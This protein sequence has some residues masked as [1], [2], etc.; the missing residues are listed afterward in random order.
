MDVS[1]SDELSLDGSESNLLVEAA[2][3]NA[4]QT[5]TK[6]IAA[7]EDE[8]AEEI[9]DASEDNSAPLQAMVA[10]ADLRTVDLDVDD[11]ETDIGIGNRATLQLEPEMNTETPVSSEFLETETA[12]TASEIEAGEA[13]GSQR[14]GAQTETHE[15]VAETPHDIPGSAA[16]K[17]EFSYVAFDD[18]LPADESIAEAGLQSIDIGVESLSLDDSLHLGPQFQEE[19]AES[20]SSSGGLVVAEVPAPETVEVADASA[21]EDAAR[22]SRA[23]RLRFVAGGGASDALVDLTNAEFV[24]GR[25]SDVAGIAD[26]QFVSP[27]HCAVR[28]E[29]GIVELSDLGSLNGTWL[30]ING[31]AVLS[32]GQEIRLGGQRFTIQSAHTQDAQVSEPADGT[33][34]MDDSQP[35]TGW[36][37]VSQGQSSGDFRRGVPNYGLRIGRLSGNLVF[38]DDTELDSLH[39][40]LLP[41]PNGVSLKDLNSYSGSWVRV[42]RSVSLSDGAEFLVGKTRIKL[43]I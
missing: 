14:A 29:D 25:D 19:L 42:D 11:S 27:S 6:R 5:P 1:G 43:E 26:D 24:V 18:G 35:S 28:M 22:E 33:K 32:D 8:E 13:A 17:D 2:R 36:A 4:Q 20:G 3:K 38:E 16:E 12:A 23:A 15:P 30:K 41:S 37:L 40:I 31:L 39:A 10:D 7:A 9:S 34:I 21:P